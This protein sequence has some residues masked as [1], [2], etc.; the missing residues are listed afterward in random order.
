MQIVWVDNIRF[1]MKL[2]L[3]TA[4]YNAEETIASSVRS[5]LPQSCSCLEHLIID[6]ASTDGTV[7]KVVKLLNAGRWEGIPQ[8]SEIGGQRSINFKTYQLNNR[9][10]RILSEKDS[11]MYDAMNKGIRMATGDVIG[12]LNSDDM[13]ADSDV[14]RKISQAFNDPSVEAVYGDLVYVDRDETSKVRRVWRSGIFTPRKLSRGWH[15][16]HPTLYIRRSVYEKY[17]LFNLEYDSAADVEF[18]MRIFHR[19]VNVCY[20]PEVFVCMRTGGVSNRF[21]NLWKQN[22]NVL[23]GMRENGIPVSP[24]YWPV[25]IT[26]RTTQ[27]LR[28]SIAQ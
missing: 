6:G 14:L 25:K 4:C 21:S 12:L 20:I 7:D 10:T 17:G 23:R 24:F 8:R 19:G 9:I 13:L 26:N 5:V 2:S 27:L 1:Y 22:R 28:G 15:P 18:M 3:I 11:G 16:A